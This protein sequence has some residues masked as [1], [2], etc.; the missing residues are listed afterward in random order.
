MVLIP[1]VVSA[2]RGGGI[3]G[4]SERIV[5]ISDVDIKGPNGEELYLAYKTTKVFFI[6]GVYMSN[7]G[8]V[9]GIKKSFN[10][11]YPL[12]EAKIK[13]LQKSG[14][15]PAVLPSYKIPFSEW[16]WGFSLWILGVI[17]GGLWLFMLPEKKDRDFTSGCKYYFGKEVSVDFGKALD[18][19]QKSANKEHAG[20]LNNLGVMY[21]KGQGVAKNY[22]L[23]ISYFEKAANKDYPNA[24]FTLGKLYLDGTLVTK[25]IK[26]ATQYFKS[27]CENG[28]AD[29]CTILKEL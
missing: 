7:D 13:E 1:N 8:Y 15:L 3:F 27:A 25:D 9:L 6:M 16:L 10:S 5:D 20:A 2:K 4:K 28:D 19:F 24:Q 29:A 18:Y 11:Y 12:S 21:L 26:K 17:I 23:S 22:E 14:A